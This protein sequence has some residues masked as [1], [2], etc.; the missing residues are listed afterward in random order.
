[1][2]IQLIEA[3]SMLVPS[4]L[5]DADYVVNP[6]TGCEFGCLYCYAS[7]M[8]RYMNEP[9]DSW[10]DYLYV[11]SNAVEI[12]EADLSRWS[13]SR[14][15]ASIF[16]SSVTD[17]Y[18]GAEK[19]YKLTRGIRAILVREAYPGVVSILTKSPLILRDVDL[20]SRL[21]HPDVGMTIT[22][23]DDTLSRFLEIRAPLASRRIATLRRLH[24]A[25]IPTY[26]FVGPLLPH[27][28]YRPDLLDA[29]FAKLAD[30]HVQSVYVEHINLKSYIRER[31]WH[32]L[33][34]ETKEIQDVYRDAA[35]SAHR[36]ALDSIVAELMQ[37]YHLR[38]RLNEVLYHNAPSEKASNPTSEIP[39]EATQNPLS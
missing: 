35:T 4:K 8:G 30:S 22:T 23:T 7:F 2:K 38:L 9:I 10:G 13:P 28:R 37:K 31:L 1:M 36:E 20:L 12:F 3:K 29:L 21:P 16:L 34:H 17:A 39:A 27:F 14:R 6:Y 26:A 11:K 32:T 19:K 25:G 18:Q 33:E 5:P 24:D 15:T